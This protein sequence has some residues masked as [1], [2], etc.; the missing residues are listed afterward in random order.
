M[1]LNEVRQFLTVN[2]PHCTVQTFSS[3]KVAGVEEASQLLQNWF[4]TGHAS[5]QQ[6]NGEISEQKKTPAK[7]D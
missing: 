4:D 1:A 2:Y 6:E 7:G 3:L 5:V